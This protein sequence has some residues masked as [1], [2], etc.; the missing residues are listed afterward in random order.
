MLSIIVDANILFSAILKIE[1]NISKL[2]I[3]NDDMFTFYTPDFTLHEINKHKAKL[4]KIANI[5]EEEYN[6]IY[7][8]I[9]HRVIIINNNI[10][11]NKYF[12]LAYEYCKDIDPNDSIYVAY[13]LYF[14]S[15]LWTG[16]KKLINGLKD[17]NIN[18]TITYN[19]LNDVFL[20][21]KE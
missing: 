7:D 13:A 3:D 5:S 4:I 12:Q 17:K 2:I 11:P 14:N 20:N 16:D 15:F 19:E 10:I 9:F 21:S 6:E 1:S 8:I 18:I